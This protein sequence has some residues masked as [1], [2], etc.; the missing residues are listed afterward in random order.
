MPCPRRT[1][2]TGTTVVDKVDLTAKEI[3]EPRYVYVLP[4]GAK[5]SRNTADRFVLVRS[6]N[7]GGT[8]CLR[9]E[10]RAVFAQKA[11][12]LEIVG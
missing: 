7:D 9:F 4:K 1:V 11:Q 12:A 5:I 10:G 8:D 2:P 3:Q 6:L